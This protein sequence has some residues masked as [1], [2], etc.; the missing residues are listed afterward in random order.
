MTRS[1][2]LFSSS[3]VSK[4]SFGGSPSLAKTIIFLTDSWT[5]NDDDTLFPMALH[6]ANH[7]RHDLDVYIVD[8]SVMENSFFF[9]TPSAAYDVEAFQIKDHFDFDT[10]FQYSPN[11]S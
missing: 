1:K 2:P 3:K 11:L 4:H 10:A 5:H 8:R 9:D 6:L 7:P